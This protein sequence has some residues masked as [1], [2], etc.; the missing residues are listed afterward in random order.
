LGECAHKQLVELAE[1]E[2][3]H[4]VDELEAVDREVEG[5]CKNSE[6]LI[7]CPL[8]LDLCLTLFE[9]F[10]RCSTSF[11]RFFLVSSN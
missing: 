5:R 4:Q 10:K 9:R 6:R 8:P 2:P 1:R 7:E 3:V 11:A